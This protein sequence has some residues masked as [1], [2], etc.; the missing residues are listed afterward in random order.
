MNHVARMPGR[1][2]DRS[3]ALMG[4]PDLPESAFGGDLPPFQRTALVRMMGIKPQGG[5]GGG[6]L[7]KVVAV[8]AAIAIPFAAPVIAS[9]I[10]LSAGI[11]A[12]TSFS[13]ATSAAIGSAI[14][15]AGL[16][17]VS[18]SVTGGNV[19]RGA[20]MGAIGGGI[21]GYTSVPASASGSPSAYGL[22]P[23]TSGTAT[24][25]SMPSATTPS[26]AGSPSLGSNL[27]FTPDYSLASGMTPSGV[28]M[29]GTGTGLVY[30][31]GGYG[32]NPAEAGLTLGGTTQSGLS[33]GLS[34]QPTNPYSLSGMSS[35]AGAPTAAADP[36][37]LANTSYAGQGS[38]LPLSSQYG[39][40]SPTDYSVTGSVATPSTAGLNTAGA[41]EFGLKA[42]TASTGGLGNAAAATTAGTTAATT[43]EKL[44]FTQALAKVPEALQAKFTDP[45]A[46]ADLTMRAGAQ[47]LT[48][49]LSDAG[50]SN[51]EKQLLQARVEEMKQNKEINNELFQTQLR[52]AYDLLGR[53]D[54][55]DPGYFGQQY[56]GAAKQRTSAQKEAALRKVNPRNKGSRAALERQYNLQSA[57]EEATAYDKGSM[58]GFDA[59]LKLT[60]QALNALPKSAPTSSADASALS[61]AYGNI[62]ERKRKS[63]EGLNKTLGP[64][65]T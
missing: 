24:G 16:G 60:Q 61:T 32:L 39:N 54:Y 1:F 34:S 10:G 28:G 64:L 30:G 56:A 52:E 43:A 46:L 6:G 18:A 35:T 57:R 22:S 47:L 8:V 53:S 26:L 17:A 13:A 55:F 3:M 5:G 33:A 59:G 11:A 7:M 15:G 2:N 63:Q 31:G 65:F 4:I 40:L 25:L 48:G 38:N 36:Y 27:S 45:K 49:Q 19:G 42:T 29:G 20:L 14:V 37:S 50:L 9:S 62:E 23:N 51:E 44:T 12:A 41:S 58:Y 21:G